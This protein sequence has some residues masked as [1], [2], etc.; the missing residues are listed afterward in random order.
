MAPENGL[1]VE[2]VQTEQMLV[3]SVGDIAEAVAV[4]AVANAASAVA[5]VVAG[6]KVVADVEADAMGTGAVGEHADDVV[7]V[8]SVGEL[9]VLAQQV[10]SFPRWFRMTLQRKR[11]T[12]RLP[13]PTRTKGHTTARTR[14]WNGSILCDQK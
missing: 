3:W 13:W 1:K 11:Q 6:V 2:E 8:G 12:P 10:R 14:I 5:V 7:A 9:D 4:A